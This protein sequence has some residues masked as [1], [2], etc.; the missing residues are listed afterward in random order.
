[1]PPGILCFLLISSIQREQNRF[2]LHLWS[3]EGQSYGE[4]IVLQKINILNKSCQEDKNVYM[5]LKMIH[6]ESLFPNVAV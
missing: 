5:S 2:K 4:G 3:L 6:G 1:M